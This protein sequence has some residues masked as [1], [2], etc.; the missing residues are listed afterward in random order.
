MAT[1]GSSKRQKQP[2]QPSCLPVSIRG[3]IDVCDVVVLAAVAADAP[4]TAL[5]HQHLV[6]QGQ[7]EG[8]L[9]VGHTGQLLGLRHSPAGRAGRQ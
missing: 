7:V 1:K 8:Q 9:D 4:P 5:L 6:P 2:Q 3:Q